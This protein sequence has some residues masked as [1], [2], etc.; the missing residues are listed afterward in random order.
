M[1]VSGSD[2]LV[3]RLLDDEVLAQHRHLEVHGLSHASRVAGKVVTPQRGEDPATIG[4]FGLQEEPDHVG[5]PG[6][7]ELDP[8]GQVEWRIESVGQAAILHQRAEARRHGGILAVGEGVLVG[9]GERPAVTR[10][11]VV[12]DLGR[13][14]RSE[15]PGMDEGEMCD[16][17][18]VVGQ[19]ASGGPHDQCGQLPGFERRIIRLGDGA[20]RR[21]WRLGSQEHHAVSHGESRRRREPG[22]R[23]QRRTRSEC[24]DLDAGA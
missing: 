20:E 19:Q 4:C 1:G 24:G 12:R 2:E 22:R 3:E 14:I 17:E 10:H 18:K 7:D 11:R 13:L 23:R 8:Q 21:Q 15:R 6:L 5:P 16:I 9:H